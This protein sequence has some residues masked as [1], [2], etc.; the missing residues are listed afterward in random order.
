MDGHMG[1]EPPNGS[2]PRTNGDGCRSGNAFN[3]SANGRALSDRDREMFALRASGWTLRQIGERY[4]ISRQRVDEIV[5]ARGGPELPA[6]IAARRAREAAIIQERS[7]EIRQ[8]WR[9][10]LPVA[11]IAAKLGLPAARVQRSIGSVLS[12]MD[13][14]Y[15]NRSIVMRTRTPRYSEEQL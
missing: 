11:A 12:P 5:R 1:S 10:G 9:S 13:R 4:G 7:T 14:A 6:V 3:G 2:G 15:R 8:W